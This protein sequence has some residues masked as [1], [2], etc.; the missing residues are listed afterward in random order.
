MKKKF[1]SG[2]LFLIIGICFIILSFL[3]FIHLLLLFRKIPDPSAISIGINYG[4]PVFFICG[5]A[6]SVFGIIRMDKKRNKINR[7]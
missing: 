3:P 5:L 4:P 2:L 7:R 6:F 1:Q